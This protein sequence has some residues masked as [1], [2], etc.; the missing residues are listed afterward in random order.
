ML[1]GK[2]KR[3]LLTSSS[4][5]FVND[6]I[7]TIIKCGERLNDMAHGEFLGERLKTHSDVSVALR[8]QSNVI[9]WCKMIVN[10]SAE[11]IE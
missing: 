2:K 7:E 3:I 4:T 6:M 11:N 10:L 5:L 8:L 9:M 1:K